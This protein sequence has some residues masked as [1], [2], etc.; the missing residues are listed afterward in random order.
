M[1]ESLEDI[2]SHAVDLDPN[3]DARWSIVYELR[4]HEERSRIGVALCDQFDE[5]RATL[6][7]QILGGG[8]TL[9]SGA[10]DQRDEY[11][12]L[13]NMVRRCQ[14][15][16]AIRAAC[17]ALSRHP[18]IETFDLMWDLRDHPSELVREGVALFN[19][20][21]PEWIPL[22]VHQS[23]DPSP[24][25]RELATDHLAGFIE[26]HD[27]RVQS[28]LLKGLDDQYPEVRRE[29][30]EGLALSGYREIADVLLDELEP[31][32]SNRADDELWVTL[33]PLR[34]AA[35]YLATR[36][37]DARFAN[38]IRAEKEWHKKSGDELPTEIQSFLDAHDPT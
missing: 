10:Y 38:L 9:E 3:S 12:A 21:A 1:I 14:S 35:W 37:D 26:Y 22:V 33:L 36:S 13:S 29:A 4:D 27:E 34:Q 32:V 6:G 16:V 2:I 5:H 15:D 28:A 7:A 23:G 24:W 19:W 11:R 20:V 30:I 25:I 17:D 31:L 18:P 8:G